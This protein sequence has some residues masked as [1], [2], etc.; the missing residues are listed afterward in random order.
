MSKFDP[1]QV[2]AASTI[3]ARTLPE[4]TTLPLD[5]LTIKLHAGDGEFDSVC[6]ADLLVSVAYHYH[7]AIAPRLSGPM[8]DADPGAPP[9][10]KIVGIY[11]VAD[12]EFTANSIKTTI[13]MDYDMTGMF[14]RHQIEAMED[15]ILTK[16]VTQ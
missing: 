5:E 4:R 15:R 14:D 8:E 3:A 9:E 13:A 2:A 12:M 10:I 7:E 16:G 1:A 6:A 11:A